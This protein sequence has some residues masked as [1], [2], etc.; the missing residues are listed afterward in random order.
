MKMTPT[1]APAWSLESF[2]PS[3]EDEE[4]IRFTATLNADLAALLERLRSLEPLDAENGSLWADAVVSYEE[5]WTRFGHLSSYLVS[6]ANSDARNEKYLAA[7]AALSG[8]EAALK[9]VQTELKRGFRNVEDAD[10]ERL[11]S[12]ENLKGA[13]WFLQRTRKEA[14]FQMDAS[15]EALA[16]DLG[17]TGMSAWGRLYET[18]VSRLTFPMRFPDGREERM[19]LSLRRSLL[20]DTDREVRKAA[21]EGG[22]ETLAAHETTFAAALNAIAG[23]RLTLDR[24]RGMADFLDP[25]LFDFAVSRSTL[26]ALVAG[27]DEVAVAIRTRLSQRARR[28]GAERLDWFD[29]GDLGAPLCS[30]RHLTYDWATGSALVGAALERTY[31]A[32]AAY[33]REAL[34]KGWVEAQQRPGK[35]PGANCMSTP[36]LREERVYMTFAGRV[37]DLQTLAHEFGHAWHSHLHKKKRRPLVF[38]NP[39]TLA[40]TASVF[41]EALFFEGVARDPDAD[42]ALKAALSEIDAERQQI[43][44]F[45]IMARFT[46]EKSF[47][48]ERKTG[49][50]SVP[51]IK[52]LM[53]EAQRRYYGDVLGTTDPYLWAS[54]LHFFMTRIRFYN[55]PYAF[56][57]LLSRALFARYRAEGATFLKQYEDFL[58]TTGQ[59]TC[60]EAVRNAFGIRIDDPQFWADAARIA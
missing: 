46:F 36:L 17:V 33:Y 40:E 4:R 18:L 24:E 51:R 57:F 22:H 34:A 41:A 47:Y 56:G 3:F 16:A 6:L 25:A 44:L 50:V 32:F 54:S 35:R 26:D 42:P 1:T 60:E 43:F 8:T 37:G 58:T 13:E 10:F 15:R 23:E 27:I 20:V 19:P 30:H 38:A 2:F 14:G 39:M 45:N 5:I 55:F 31:P 49:E 53:E 48:E 28:L 9:K 59:A 29:L 52:A 7:K 12:S 11:V 21:F